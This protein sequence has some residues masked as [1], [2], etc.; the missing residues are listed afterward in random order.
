MAYIDTGLKIHLWE[1][2]AEQSRCLGEAR[3][4]ERITK[5]KTTL[6]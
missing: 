3:I 1:M 2:A 6:I 4:P 5:V